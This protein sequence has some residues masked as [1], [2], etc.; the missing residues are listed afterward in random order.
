MYCPAT[1]TVTAGDTVTWTNVDLAAHTVTYEGPGGP[2]D[3]GSM[4]QGRS[5]ST[6]FDV[7]GTYPYYCRFHPGMAGSIVVRSVS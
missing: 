4:A 1:V 5:W 6:R 2:V 7:A 3:S